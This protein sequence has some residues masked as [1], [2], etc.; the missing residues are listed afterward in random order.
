AKAE[1]Q[2]LDRLKPLAGRTVLF[3]PSNVLSPHSRAAACLRAWSFCHPLVP[4]HLAGCCIAGDELFSAIEQE[5]DRREPRYAWYGVR[6]PDRP[7]RPW[8][9]QHHGRGLGRRCLTVAATLLAFLL[10]GR[11]VGLLLRVC[12][13]RPRSWDVDT[14]YPE[15]T[16]ELL[17]LYNQYN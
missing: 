16:R 5:L 15:S 8:L 3:R 6:G 4:E 13:G 14:L 11:I 17:A 2:A 12:G 10:V 1:T 9:R 7:W